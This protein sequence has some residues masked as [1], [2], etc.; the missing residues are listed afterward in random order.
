M[1]QKD[2]THLSKFTEAEAQ[3][4]F[5]RRQEMETAKKS[6]DWIRSLNLIII[7][8]AI[9]QSI[10]FWKWIVSELHLQDK[11]LSSIEQFIKGHDDF[12]NRE[13]QLLDLQITEKLRSRADAQYTILVAEIA[14]LKNDI[15]ELKVV[16]KTHGT[17]QAK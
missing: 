8:A 15:A 17:A 16:V 1:L 13:K 14:A 7:T 4:E 11:R 12:V 5:E 9:A 3:A 2:T 6:R 10:V